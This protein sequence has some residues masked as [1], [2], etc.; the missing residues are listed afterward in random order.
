MKKINTES[1]KKELKGVSGMKVIRKIIEWLIGVY[2]KKEI[3][4]ESRIKKV[5]DKQ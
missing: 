3:W 2:Y 5:Y 4:K 1:K